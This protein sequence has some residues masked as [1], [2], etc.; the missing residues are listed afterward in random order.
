MRI[1]FSKINTQ[2]YI[3]IFAILTICVLVSK[4]LDPRIT[5]ELIMALFMFLYWSRSCY[6]FFND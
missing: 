1:K 4:T 3:F 5:M 2:W 6:C